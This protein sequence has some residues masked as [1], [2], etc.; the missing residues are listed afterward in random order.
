MPLNSLPP[1][2]PTGR[3]GSGTPSLPGG[4][5]PVSGPVRAQNFSISKLQQHSDIEQSRVSIN[6]IMRERR[7]AAKAGPTT[8]I[9]RGSQTAATTSI[10]RPAGDTREAQGTS[11][12]DERRFSYVRR[13]IKEKQAAGDGG[14]GESKG[15]GVKTGIGFRKGGFHKSF[16]KLIRA[17]RSEFNSFGP[18]ERAFFEKLI[19]EHA[20]HKAVGAGFHRHD[21]IS[22]HEEVQK[23]HDSGR[24][25]ELNMKRFKKLIDKLE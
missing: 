25:S 17:N 15:L 8:S 20:A 7:E 18:Q 5:L 1:I 9:T 3:L 12:A 24:L 14:A 13:L 22:M 10:N 21:R 23:A 11:G 16:G 6:Q 4:R 2:L 19:G